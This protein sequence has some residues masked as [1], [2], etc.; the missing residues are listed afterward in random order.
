MLID[1][2]GCGLAFIKNPRAFFE[3]MRHYYGDTFILHIFGIRMFCVFSPRGLR[4][5]YSVR[6]A[7]A[8]FTEA[9][10]GLLGLKLPHEVIAEGNLSKFHRGLKKHL[11]KNYLT[12]VHRAIE[13]SL[14][15]LPLTGEFEIF[16]HMKV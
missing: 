16:S 12:H 15:A 10:R 9:T 5:L 11:V 13:T 3:R 4:E 14:N 6:E 7:D 8:S 1:G 2:T